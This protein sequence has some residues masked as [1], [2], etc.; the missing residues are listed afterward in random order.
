[1]WEQLSLNFHLLHLVVIVFFLGRKVV[2]CQVCLTLPPFKV[3]D[4][5]LGG[6]DVVWSE[7]GGCRRGRSGWTCRR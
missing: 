7:F 2:L 1:M 4:L 6:L 5:F 3:S